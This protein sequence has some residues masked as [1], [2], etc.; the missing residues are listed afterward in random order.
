MI[1]SAAML[2][3]C[4]RNSSLFLIFSG[5]V[6]GRSSASAARLTGDA[7]NFMPRPLGRSGWVATSLMRKPAATSFSS[8]GTANSGV[9]QNT[10]SIMAALPFAL[11]HQLAD[12]AL[13]HVAF[14]RADVVDVE[15]AV[16]V[17]RF[18]HQG[19]RQQVFP[20]DFKCFAFDVLRPRGN[21]ARPRH[22][23]SEF[24]QAQATFVGCKPPFGVDDLWIHEHDLR[25]GIFL[26]G[27]INDGNALADANLRRGQT[28]AV[29]GV[30][31]FKHVI[32]KLAQL[33]VEDGN[34]GAR[35]LQDRIAEFHDGVDHL[36]VSQLLTVAF[37]IP[38]HFQ[39]RIASELFQRAARQSERHH[40][41]SGHS[42]GWHDADVRALVGGLYR[43]AAGEVHR[44]QRTPQRGNRL[45]VTAHPNVL[46]VGN[47]TLQTTGVVRSP[48][49][50]GERL[51]PLV[52]V[53]YFI[54]HVGAE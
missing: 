46:A 1:A 28:D 2:S 38:S 30:H 54:M 9:P 37:E 11:L 21:V 20:A 44:A 19:A 22:L 39:H 10:K 33:F 45:Q 7:A 48:R 6:M 49:E 15:L 5:W 16:E 14:Q 17:I 53:A 34:R 18:V 27:D 12:L 24:G 50:A 43:L 35:L 8:V 26:K 25:L 40:G 13:Q 41:F 52:L 36:E 3:N 29:R 32:D 47:A 4:A 23:L 42:C 31:A 51:Y